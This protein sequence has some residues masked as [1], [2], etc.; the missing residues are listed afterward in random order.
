MDRHSVYV[1]S[2]VFYA[3]ITSGCNAP[4]IEFI[5]P[6]IP[7]APPNVTVFAGYFELRN[8]TPATIVLTTA[9]SPYFDAVE[10]HRTMEENGVVKMVQEDAVRVPS[11]T[12]HEF[13][14]GGFHLMLIDPRAPVKEGA[15]IPV[16]LDIEGREAIAVDF[17]VRRMHFDL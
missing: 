6:W 5:D 11:G 4:D 1:L 10:V 7:E 9:E 17:T 14:P 13:S 2:A 15:I 8:N 16:E 3:V 12:V